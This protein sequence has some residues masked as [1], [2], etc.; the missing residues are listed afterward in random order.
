MNK[1]LAHGWTKGT[2]SDI[3]E[4]NP[5]VSVASLG[6]D[7][8]VS[9]FSM[10]DVGENGRI[11]NHQTRRLAEVRSGFTRFEEGDILFAKITPCMQ[12][13]KGALASSLLN[14]HGFGSTEFHVL[15]ASPGND[16]GYLL[17]LSISS[18]VRQKAVA[19]F[20][21]S[22][23]QQ[24]VDQKF[25]SVFPILI[26]PPSEQPRIAKILTTLDDLI[27]K[28]EGLIVKFEAIKRGMMHDLFT[29]GVDAHSHLRP[30]HVKAPDLY[31]R[32][33]LGWIPKDWWVATIGELFEKRTEHGKEGLPVMSVVMRDGLV[34]RSSVDRRVESNLPPQGHALVLKGDIAY[35]M[36]RMWQGVLGR[37]SFD[38][39]ISP[40][41]VVLKPKDTINTRFAA[42]L[43]SDK[44]SI[45]KFRQFSQGVVD[46]RLRLYFHDLVHISFAV[47]TSLDEQE[48]IA[49]RIEACNKRIATEKTALEQYQRLRLGLMQDLLTGKVRV[50]VDDA[51]EDGQ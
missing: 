21:G 12:N 47:P 19:F 23:G 40:A 11:I 7:N 32:T 18:D 30:P 8:A 39:L 49:R 51:G 29:R 15:R 14:G 3:A 1:Q 37:A 41:Y 28:T 46:D 9:F 50:N 35:N 43:F 20:T 44:R 16:R 26:P 2:F 22:A 42:F 10:S 24:R 38:C 34:E 48:E 36:M 45:Q 27:E 33:N 5:P 6:S 17:Y 4:I 13:G 25:F 31:R